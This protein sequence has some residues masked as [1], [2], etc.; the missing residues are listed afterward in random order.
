M[1][2]V[3]LI[4]ALVEKIVAKLHAQAK[5]PFKHRQYI[6]NSSTGGPTNSE[7]GDSVRRRAVCC[8][9]ESHRDNPGAN[10]PQG[11]DPVLR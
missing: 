6:L 8:K 1:I 9:S 10:A 5:M 2:A 3:E 7:I 4:P 11:L